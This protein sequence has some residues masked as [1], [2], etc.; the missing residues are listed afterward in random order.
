MRVAQ[1]QGPVAEGQAGL[2]QLRPRLRPDD[3]VDDEPAALL[4]GADRSFC[5]R[6][7]PPSQLGDVDML[8]DAGQ[9]PLD[10]ADV[11]AEVPVPDGSHLS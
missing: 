9:P 4:E 11:L 2:D 6:A 8:P 10:V 7:E 3:A 1:V 5:R